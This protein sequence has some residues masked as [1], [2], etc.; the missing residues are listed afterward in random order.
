[1]LFQFFLNFLYTV[2]DIKKRNKNFICD[3]S[4]TTR[5]QQIL[6]SPS[7]AEHFHCISHLMNVEQVFSKPCLSLVVTHTS[8]LSLPSPVA[9]GGWK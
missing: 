2:F 5:I 1:M 6:F 8:P 4:K 3:T 9:L 7:S